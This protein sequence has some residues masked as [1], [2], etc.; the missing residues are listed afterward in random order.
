MQRPSK[1]SSCHSTGSRALTHSKFQDLV[2]DASSLT[3]DSAVVEAFSSE[4]VKGVLPSRHAVADVQT[5]VPYFLRL[6]ASNSLGFGEY[7]DN[8]A[9]AKAAQGPA[10]PGNLSSGVALH[11][12]EVTKLV[13]EPNGTK[14]SKH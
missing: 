7:G 13:F 8:L 5:G 6:A 12:D 1:Q 11:V 9:V 3:G 2:G 4:I 14:C 10:A